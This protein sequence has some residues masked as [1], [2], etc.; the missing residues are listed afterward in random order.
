VRVETIGNATLYLGD[1][2]QI[3]P[4]IGRVDAIIT[5]PPYSSGGLHVASK[6]TKPADKYTSA[7]HWSE[8]K[9]YPEFTGDSCDQ[10]SWTLLCRAW[11]AYS[12]ALCGRGAHLYCFTDWRQIGACVAA[13]QMGGWQYRGLVVWDK[14]PT[15]R[16]PY[17]GAWRHGAEFLVWGT[18][19]QPWTCT[20]GEWV[21]GVPPV[22][23]VIRA[24]GV[25]D[26]QHMTEKPVD[27]VEVV[28]GVAAPAGGM[29]LDPFMGSGTTGVA[30]VSTGRKFVGIEM[31]PTYFDIACE[32]I[33]AAHSQGRLFA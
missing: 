30:C 7:G 32:R 21:E 8:Q 10:W 13:T 27:V 6:R 12:F 17:P 28:C 26:K 33:N 1:C 23:S 11:M 16:S 9:E 22:H 31:E 19:G 14:G 3:L 18:K 2:L 29:I 15:A 25:R 24:N 20:N 4:T 5:D